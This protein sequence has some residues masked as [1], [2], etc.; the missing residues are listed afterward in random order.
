MRKE[1]RF[2]KQD[3][4]WYADV[5]NH[6]LEENEMVL[7]ADNALESLSQG[8]NVL[9]LTISTDNEDAANSL[10]SFRMKDHD[11]GGASYTTDIGDIREIW[12]CNVTHDVLGEHP[13]NIH[14][15]DIRN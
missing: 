10:V 9:W 5:P 3:N 8:K 6:T 1:V 4:R 2:F 11:N 15:L 7:G 12:I 14:L 13:K